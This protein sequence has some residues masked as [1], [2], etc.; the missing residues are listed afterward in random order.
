MGCWRG[1]KACAEGGGK[2]WKRWQLLKDNTVGEGRL[3]SRCHPLA[4]LYFAVKQG[5]QGFPQ[6][7]RILEGKIKGA[8]NGLMA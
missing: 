5:E 6:C 1:L 8:S 2:K 4:W 7:G 3:C